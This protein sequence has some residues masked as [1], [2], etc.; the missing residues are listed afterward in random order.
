MAVLPGLY[1]PIRI[2]AELVP[3]LIDEIPVLAVFASRLP[4]TSVI[5]GAGE[6]RHKESDRLAAIERN[7]ARLG[8]DC[9]RT[10]DE[11]RIRGTTAPLAGTVETAGDHRMAMAF[12][13]LS[14]LPDVR[15]NVETP[16]S[17]DVSFPGYW[18]RL[19][20][21]V[22]GS[23]VQGVRASGGTRAVSSSADSFTIAIDGPAASGKSTTARQVAEALGALH[24]N[25]GRLYRAIAWAS[26]TEGWIDAEDFDKR[27]RELPL[28]LAAEGDDFVLRVRG[29]PPGAA[30]DDPDVVSRVSEVSARRAVRERVTQTLRQAA[31]GQRVVSDGRDVGTTVFPDA[32]LK[33]FLTASP[34]ERARRRLLDYAREPS[35]EAIAREAANLQA[36]DQAD[37][38]R[39]LS[40]LRR[41]A[42]AVDLDTT[43]LSPSEVVEQIVQLARLRGLASGS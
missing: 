31:A 35:P 17:V 30:L 41:A 39:E 38:T 32:A 33:I 14:T 40:P 10:D 34:E 36:R 16:E 12:G 13:V 11:L 43:R 2:G 37:S 24:L 22:P 27:L 6:L 1:R 20:S 21:V 19:A 15:I 8:V 42:D 26:L 29:E 4:G 23:S 18:G 28:T 9:S 3:R 7:L 25:S 5:E